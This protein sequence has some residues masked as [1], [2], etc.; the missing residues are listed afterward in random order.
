MD[1]GVI[2]IGRADELPGSSP[3]NAMLALNKAH[4]IEL[5]PLDGAAL[6]Q[7]V[8]RALAAFRVG[9][10]DA[11]LIAL[12]QEAEYDSPNFLWFRERL[13]R[14]VYVDRVV[15]SP[16]A[17]GRGLARRLY[18]ALFEAALKAGHDRIVCEVNSSPPNPGSDAFHLALGFSPV[19]VG[20]RPERGKSVRYL[21]RRLEQPPWK[22]TG[23]P[24]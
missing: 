9:T 24:P 23:S 19:G 8:R 14:F 21:E 1:Q 2:T 18:E 3:L 5:S 22:T 12:D 13:P 17:R 7:L 20:M 15:V 10:V 4:E 16:S 6:Q 11:F